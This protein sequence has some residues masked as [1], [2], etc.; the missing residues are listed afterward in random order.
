[1]TLIESASTARLV[2]EVEAH[3]G[4]M[5]IGGRIAMVGWATIGDRRRHKWIT[6]K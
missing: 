4:K 1:M 2:D 6:L 3:G 5:T